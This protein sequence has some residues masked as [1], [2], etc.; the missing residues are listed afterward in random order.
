[1]TNISDTMAENEE[2]IMEGFS[3]LKPSHKEIVPE[4]NQ[5]LL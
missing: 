3:L 5:R 4:K 2:S 1:M